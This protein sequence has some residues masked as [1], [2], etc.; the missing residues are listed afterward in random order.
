MSV[1]LF[2]SC[3]GPSILDGS[4]TTNSALIVGWG[5]SSVTESYFS[6]IGVLNNAYPI[7]ILG[8]GDGTPSTSAIDVTLS[9]DP[10]STAIDGGE[11][12]IPST[13]FT[14]PAGSSFA[15]VPIDI[16]TGLFNA[17]TPSKVVI[18]VATST[19]G[20]VIDAL[21]GQMTINFVGC[22]SDIA[23]HTYMMTVTSSTGG[24]YGPV[25]E[26]VLMES[27][28]NF[29]TYSAGT[30]DP[31]L[32]PGHGVRFEDICGNLTIPSQGLVDV[33]SNSVTAH[34]PSTV[35]PNGDF[36][37]NYTIGF[38]SGPRDYVATYIK[39]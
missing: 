18:N 14:I 13:S 9:V 28:N 33:Y 1:L 19:N 30:W 20:V 27:V 17:T 31:P 23:N 37:L 22:Q 29:M 6:D 8:G 10:S 39:Q 12:S 21:A 38:G 34:G 36:T 15:M 11:Y 26:T 35:Q 32:N 2:S 3:T 7:N 24:Q 5:K 25:L 16:N 4:N